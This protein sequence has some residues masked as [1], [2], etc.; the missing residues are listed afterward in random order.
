MNGEGK[1]AADAK[2]RAKKIRTRP[3]MRDF[4]KEL[5]CVSFLLQWITFIR[6]A[7]DRY[8]FSNKFPILAFAL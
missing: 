7:N 4:A 5:G 8:L 3:Q 2:N 1:A 6:T